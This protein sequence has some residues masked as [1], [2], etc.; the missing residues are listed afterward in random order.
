MCMQLKTNFT[1]FIFL[2]LE[3]TVLIDRLHC[4][5]V[6]TLNSA[7]KNNIKNNNKRKKETKNI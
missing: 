6:Y 4:H 7:E 1:L 2:P 3:I 5:P